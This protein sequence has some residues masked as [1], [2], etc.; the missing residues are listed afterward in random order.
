MA[1]KQPRIPA[2]RGEEMAAYIGKLTMFL[3]DFCQEAWMESQLQEKKLEEM[4]RKM[5]LF[6]EQRSQSQ[7]D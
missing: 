6:D 7:A 4:G 5:K 2:Y 1:F 3:R